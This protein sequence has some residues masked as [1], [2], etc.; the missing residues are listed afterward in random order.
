M[1]AYVH[2]GQ[3]GSLT[4]RLRSFSADLA[5][6]DSSDILL[7]WRPRGQSREVW[8]LARDHFDVR[9]NHHTIRKHFA[10]C[11]SWHSAATVRRA[12]RGFL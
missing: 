8:S 4:A 9:F 3:H 5:I 2:A 11:K 10:I 6:L 12:N 1:R 7:A